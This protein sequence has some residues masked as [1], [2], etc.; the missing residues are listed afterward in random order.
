MASSNV[1]ITTH[2][3]SK[4]YCKRFP[5]LNHQV[6]TTESI[7]NIVFVSDVYEN[8]IPEQYI[9]NYLHCYSIRS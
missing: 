4:M 2:F 6:P 8:Y 1:I 3:N 9:Y 5:Y 7:I